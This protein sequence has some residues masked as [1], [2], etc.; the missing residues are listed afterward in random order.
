MVSMGYKVREI[1]DL[2]P[3]EVD[4]IIKG[5]ELAEERENRR[6]AYFTTWTASGSHLKPKSIKFEKILKP[7]LPKK[8]FS[9]ERVE[10]LKNDKQFLSSLLKGR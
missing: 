4:Q 5:F 9:E 2:Q 8:D 10:Q 7:L 6:Q 1:D 3:Q